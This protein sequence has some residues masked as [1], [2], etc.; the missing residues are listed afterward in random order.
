MFFCCWIVLVPSNFYLWLVFEMIKG[1]VASNFCPP[2]LKF[3]IYYQCAVRFG[4]FITLYGIEQLLIWWV[5][6]RLTVRKVVHKTYSI[7]HVY[8][9][10]LIKNYGFDGCYCCRKLHC[11]SQEIQGS[12]STVGSW[13][14]I[15][16]FRKG[17]LIWGFQASVILKLSCYRELSQHFLSMWKLRPDDPSWNWGLISQFLVCGLIC[18]REA[19]VS[20]WKAFASP[21]LPTAEQFPGI[22]IHFSCTPENSW[23]LKQIH[24]PDLELVWRCQTSAEGRFCFFLVPELYVWALVWKRRSICS[25]H[26]HCFWQPAKLPFAASSFSCSRNRMRICQISPSCCGK[27]P[28]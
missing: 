11:D 18:Q 15:F 6:L 8:G 28:I 9:F 7:F 3:N 19:V 21:S 20:I 13:S 17:K 23:A 5:F 24:A 4:I 25:F 16:C 1:R 2:P 27:S 14:F 22:L 26:H 12:F 10:I